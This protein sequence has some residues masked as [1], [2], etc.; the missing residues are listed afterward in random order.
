MAAFLGLRVSIP[1][2]EAARGAAQMQSVAAV[3]LI[4]PMLSPKE[5]AKLL[6]EAAKRRAGLPP[7]MA[8]LLRFMEA[9][10]VFMAARLPFMQAVIHFLAATLPFMEATHA[11]CE[12]T[13]R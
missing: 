11:E 5:E 2:T 6:M 7:F 13:A 8:A 4:E 1:R 10:L 3:G 9:A 12:E